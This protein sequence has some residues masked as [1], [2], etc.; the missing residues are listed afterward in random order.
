MPIA[1]SAVTAKDIAPILNVI[2]VL[3]KYC[4]NP[5]AEKKK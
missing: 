2:I 1:A 3:S 5:V 4:I